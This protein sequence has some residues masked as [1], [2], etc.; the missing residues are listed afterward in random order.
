MRGSVLAGV[1]ALAACGDDDDDTGPPDP[2]P[3]GTTFIGD[4]AADPA[5]ELG[6]IRYDGTFT[7]LTEGATLTLFTPPQGGKI[8][9]VGAHIQNM[10][11]CGAVLT[12][13]LRDPSRE[14]EPVSVHEGRTVR[15]LELDD[16]PGWG[17]VPTG[18]SAFT[19]L[20]AGANLPACHNYEARDMDGCDW[21][22]DVSVEDRAGRA[23]SARL[24]VTLACPE[25]DPGAEREDERLE[26][27]CECAANFDERDCN[28]LQV[29]Q[30]APP[31]C[32]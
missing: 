20:A 10:D 3:P 8:V 27:E 4:E 18:P 29:W 22:L 12:G 23:V 7:P 16:R 24:P 6:E 15:F 11:G 28:D 32:Q 19:V 13:R 17:G 5:I 21:I 1:L 9:L 30:D 25:D 31:V 26:C 14:G 2:C